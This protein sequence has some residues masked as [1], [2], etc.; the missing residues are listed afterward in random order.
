L[1]GS[2]I[3]LADLAATVD[4]D[5]TFDFMAFPAMA[6]PPA[7][8]GTQGGMGFHRRGLKLTKDVDSSMKGKNVIVWKIFWSD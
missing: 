1:K 5:A 4:L 6:M 3:F 7:P 8:V 2:A